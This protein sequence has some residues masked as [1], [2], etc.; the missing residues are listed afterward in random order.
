VVGRSRKNDGFRDVSKVEGGRARSDVNATGEGNLRE[1]KQKGT[2]QTVT[3]GRLQ[4]NR[5]GRDLGFAVSG[6]DDAELSE[7]GSRAALK[8][9][10]T[11]IDAARIYSHKCRRG[12]RGSAVRS[13]V[14]PRD[15][16]YSYVKG[17]TR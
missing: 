8:S 13:E 4:K 10:G 7:R 14:R 1:Y 5:K 9:S 12:G 6:I 15:R 11:S 17:I 2:A 3:T 16:K